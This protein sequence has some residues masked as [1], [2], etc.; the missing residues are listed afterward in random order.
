MSDERITDIDDGAARRYA[1]LA[2]TVTVEDRQRLAPPADLWGA[3]AGA[4]EESSPAGDEALGGVHEVPPISAAAYKPQ[5]TASGIDQAHAVA[6]GSGVVVP[7]RRRMSTI[8]LSA[9]AA[10]VL[11][12]GVVALVVSGGDDDGVPAGEL[13]ATGTLE[14]LADGF[15]GGVEL[16]DVDGRLGLD[17]EVGDLPDTTDAYYELWLIKDLETGEM[18]SLGPIDGSGRVDLPQGLDPAQYATVDISVEPLDGV[19]THSG[20]SVLR[21][22]LDI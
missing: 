4:L 12:L 19:P 14:P 7:L 10:V 6:P 5:E 1:A 9:A 15:E 8:V 17:L 16:V 2:R 22:E 11:V 3:I 20:Q 21:G 18:Q 13:V